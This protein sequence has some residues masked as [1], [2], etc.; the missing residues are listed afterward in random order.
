MCYTSRRERAGRDRRPH[1]AGASRA[2]GRGRDR[3]R[4]PRRPVPGEPAGDQ[5]PPARAARGRPGPVPYRGTTT[6]LRPRPGSLARARRVARALPGSLG[7]AAGRPGHRDRP[8]PAGTTERRDRMTD[9]PDDR[10]GVVTPEPD[11]GRRLVFR[12]SWPDPIDD[13]WSALTDNERSARWIGTYEGERGPGATG[14][15]T[16]THEAGSDGMPMSIVECYPPRRLVLQCPE[17][18]TWRVELDLTEKDGR[19]VLVFTQVLPT[20]EG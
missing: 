7:A 20:A 1:P 2:P 18:L 11:G 9:S 8:R 6:A 19:T 5:P 4:G 16:M 10:R 17:P 12:R 13:V 14:I 15:F 3:R